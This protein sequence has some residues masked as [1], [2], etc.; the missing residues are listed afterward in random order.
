MLVSSADCKFV[1]FYLVFNQII[2]LLSF[3]SCLYI[4]NTS[5]FCI[6]LKIFSVFMVWNFCVAKSSLFLS[7]MVS[8]LYIF[9]GRSFL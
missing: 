8:R 5:S 9:L 4:R 3:E 1:V 7:F 2:C 6:L